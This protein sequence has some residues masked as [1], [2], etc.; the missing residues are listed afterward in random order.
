MCLFIVIIAMGSVTSA[1]YLIEYQNKV[2]VIDIDRNPPKIELVGL[3]NTNVGYEKYA[4]QTH[5]ITAQIKVTEEHIISNNMSLENLVV[6]VNGKDAEIQNIKV[7]EK[8]REGDSI[9]YD[10]ILKK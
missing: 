6:Q 4:N 1:K 2:A 5:T 10:I 8:K 7:V 9:Y 3:Q